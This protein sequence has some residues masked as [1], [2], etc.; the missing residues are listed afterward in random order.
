VDSTLLRWLMICCLAALLLVF[1]S[2]FGTLGHQPNAVF[3]F[4]L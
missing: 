2:A 3:F 4:G 1:L